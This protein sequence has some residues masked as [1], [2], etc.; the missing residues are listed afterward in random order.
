MSRSFPR[1]PTLVGPGATRGPKVEIVIVCEGEKTEPQYFRDCVEYFGAGTVRLSII[2]PAGV[3]MTLVKCAIQE[4]HEL[5]EKN[6]RS[7]DSFDSCFRVWA[8]F[9]RDA[10]PNV[11][12]AIALAQS[13]SID[14]AFSN[15]C[16]EL[17]P[18]L[19]LQDFGAQKGRH[20]LQKLLKTLMISYDHD[21]GAII[22]FDQIR[23]GF[24]DAYTRAEQHLRDREAEGV[25]LGNPATTVGRLVRKIIENGKHGNRELQS[26]LSRL[27][28]NPAP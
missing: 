26:I 9:D 2:A 27:P 17:W 25:K 1:S 18:I 24:V 11:T 10:H 8:V 22:D 5:I 12:T 20:E 21:K 14:V 4:R 16:F 13:Y 3:P 19:H 23:E 7:K 28:P 15:P 6:R